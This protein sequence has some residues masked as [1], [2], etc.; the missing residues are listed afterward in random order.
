[1]NPVLTLPIQVFTDAQ[2]AAKKSQS[3][4]D[5]FFHLRIII[6]TLRRK[7]GSSGVSLSHTLRKTGRPTSDRI[8]TTRC[9]IFATVSSSLRWV[10]F[11][12]AKIPIL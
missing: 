1:M 9:P 12:A 3:P 11:A 7:E 6:L 5:M 4:Q 8:T 10:I 2:V